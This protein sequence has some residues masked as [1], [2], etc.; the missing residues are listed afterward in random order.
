[1][2]RIYIAGMISVLSAVCSTPAL[3]LEFNDGKVQVHGFAS[4]GIV[5]S[6]GNNFYGDS[7]NNISFDFREIGINASYRPRPDLQFSAQVINLDAGDVSENGLLLDYALVD[8]T[9]SSTEDTQF[10]IRLGR[11]KNPF[12]LYTTTR[13]VAFTRPSIV[14]PQSI[15]FDKA[16]SLA[17]SS[18]GVG[19]YLNK[20]SNYGGINF[21]LVVGNA[22]VDRGS[23]A[24]FLRVDLPGDM[25]SEKPSR[26]MRI[27][28]TTPNDRLRIAFTAANIDLKYDA[29][30]H[31]FDPNLAV[32]LDPKIIS[33][34]YS[35]ENWELTAEYSQMKSSITRSFL[36][37]F[38]NV[39]E[40]YY[41]QGSYQFTPTLQAVVRYD[42]S[43][44]NKSDHS[45]KKLSAE[46]GLPAHVFFAKDWMVGLRYDVTP[47][48]MIRGEWHHINGTGW[49]SS[50]DNN[51]DP[52][53]MERRW[54]M[55]MFMGSW[56]F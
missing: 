9:I 39:I 29:T 41:V 1:M 15:Y 24:T 52:G 32:H 19:F 44:N 10:G 25:K 5:S 51:A 40:G 37:N 33:A 56:R 20:E 13:D 17:L 8:Y 12:G 27:M 18:D 26:L 36:P 31:E 14:L 28:Y 49:L 42:A 34:Q 21:D 23:E 50:L 46:T 55:L 11:V 35:N 48:F 4:Q 6:T 38:N 3:A 45:G 16:R 43:F 47:T 2:L 53:A 30:S 54:D 22:N 7:S